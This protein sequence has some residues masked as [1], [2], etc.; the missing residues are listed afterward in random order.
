MNGN[1]DA[2]NAS[3]DKGFSEYAGSASCVSC[4][5]AICDSL[6]S[7]A[8]FQTS[9][10]ANE[11]NIAGSFE[12]GKNQYHYPSGGA[13]AME[14]SA[15]GLYQVGYL[16]DVEKKRQ[17]FDMVIGSGTHGQSYAT[18]NGN[19]LYQMP[20]TYFTSA[21]AWCN[22]P[23]YPNK[24]A[25]NRP[26]TSRCMECHATYL[27]KISPESEE[28]ESFDRNQVILGVDCERCHG[29][30]AKHVQFHTQNPAAKDP[31]EILALS[32]FTRTQSLDLCALC[33]GGRLQKIKPSF[34]FKA[35]DKRSDFFV[36]DSTVPD[37]N[38]MDV[39]G[40]QYGLMAASKCFRMSNTLTCN[41][42]HSAHGNEKGN[43]ALFSQ[44]CLTC[45]SSGH[46]NTVTCKMT[47][48]LGAA[49]NTNCTGC[50]MPEQPSR[51]ISVYLEGQNIPTPA[52][53]HTH[54]IKA[55]PEA[56]KKMMAAFQ[57]NL[58]RRL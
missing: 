25:F 45:H 31:H 17:R 40:N 34:Q 50:H 55:Y 1:D 54:L 58:Q 52:L 46:D 15:G 53:M 22:S 9:A 7:T 5:K 27:G 42:C 47:A 26:I 3:T 36:V 32:A 30:S 18:W 37:V 21:N 33:H 13:V 11:K 10:V 48:T 29:P 41:S 39:H 24:L 16:N 8:H 35:G 38:T 12:P 6:A 2:R 28:P 20:I 19:K 51:A 43:S 56:T 49:I 4:H 23:G 44:R 14:K 57:K